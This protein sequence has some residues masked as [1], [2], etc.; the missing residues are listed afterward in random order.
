M[1]PA[2]T[3]PAIVGCL[4]ANSRKRKGLD[5][6][7]VAAA[8]GLSQA[9]W[10]RIER[11]E[12]ALSVDQL[13]RAAEVLGENTWE[14]LRSADQAVS[15]LKRDGVE[16]RSLRAEEAVQQGLVLIGVAALAILVAKLI[17]K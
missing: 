5:Q 2:T 16:V 10:S 6:A 17:S 7:K 9:S 15:G 3:Y 11:G 12:T 13:H 1:K 14:V 4:L 8:M